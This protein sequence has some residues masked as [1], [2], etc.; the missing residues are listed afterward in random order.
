MPEFRAGCPRRA[1]HLPGCSKFEPFNTTSSGKLAAAASA[2]NGKTAAACSSCPRVVASSFNPAY[3]VDLQSLGGG[4][5]GH[6]HNHI[7]GDLRNRSSVLNTLAAVQGANAL[8][9]WAFPMM[10][11]DDSNFRPLPADDAYRAGGF[12]QD[13]PLDCPLPPPPPLVASQLSFDENPFSRF[14]FNFVSLARSIC[15]LEAAFPFLPILH[16]SMSP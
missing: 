10:N 13:F 7:N 14:G 12:V 16:S 1:L 11:A 2:S 5:G 9:V 4:G 6:N 8:F 3:N 15:A